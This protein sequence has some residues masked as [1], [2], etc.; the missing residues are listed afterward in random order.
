MNKQM[1]SGQDRSSALFE[2]NA[3]M[4]NKINAMFGQFKAKDEYMEKVVQAKELEIQL[5]KAKLEASEVSSVQEMERSLVE[6]EQVFK[7]FSSLT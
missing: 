3:Q 4:A 7:S 5:V 2:E 1:K 6:K